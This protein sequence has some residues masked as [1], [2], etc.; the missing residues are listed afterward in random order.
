MS[1]SLRQFRQ[2]SDFRLSYPGIGGIHFY[3]PPPREGGGGGGGEDATIPGI[4]ASVKH[5]I[6]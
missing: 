6:L 3:R 5:N 4:Y 1:I 2:M